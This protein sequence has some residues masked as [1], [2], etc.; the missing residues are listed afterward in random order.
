MILIGSL[1][2]QLSGRIEAADNAPGACFTVTVP[3]D[4]R[5]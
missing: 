3:V 2:A 4:D 5:A 1:L